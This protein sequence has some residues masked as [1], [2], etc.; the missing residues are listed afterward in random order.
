MNTPNVEYHFVIKYNTQEG[1]FEIDYEAQ[2]TNFDG[3]PVY[4][5]D[6]GEWRPLYDGEWVK[7]GTEYNNAADDLWRLVSELNSARKNFTIP[8]L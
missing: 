2:S 8:S 7:D 3:K 4:D 1:R 5:L 6:R